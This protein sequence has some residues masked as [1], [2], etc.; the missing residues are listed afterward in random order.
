[1]DFQSKITIGK[2]VDIERPSYQESMYNHLKNKYG[3]QYIPSTEMKN[4]YGKNRN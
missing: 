1:M 2:F 4:V 3:D